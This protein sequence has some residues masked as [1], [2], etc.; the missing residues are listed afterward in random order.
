MSVT[1]SQ[2]PPVEWR[3]KTRRWVLMATHVSVCGLALGAMVVLGGLADP[4]GETIGGFSF[5]P[6]VIIGSIAVV[7]LLTLMWL[8]WWRCPHC[9]GFLGQVFAIRHCPVCGVRLD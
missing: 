8:R 6:L 9:N 7:F 5:Y 1:G 2:V 3:L 4:G